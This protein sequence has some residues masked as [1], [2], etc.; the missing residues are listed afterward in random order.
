MAH[1]V[2]EQIKIIPETEFAVE[3]TYDPSKVIVVDATEWGLSPDHGIIT[4][5]TLTT[6]G[7]TTALPGGYSLTGSMTVPARMSQID[8]LNGIGFGMS[9]NKTI[10]Y[11]IGTNAAT[12]HGSVA[13]PS[14]R[15][16]PTFTVYHLYPEPEL[17]DVAMGT[18]F[19]NM[20][21][22]FATDRVLTYSYDI[23][24][25]KNKQIKPPSGGWTDPYAQNEPM[26]IQ[27]YVRALDATLYAD[28]RVV[29]YDPDNNEFVDDDTQYTPVDQNGDNYYEKVQDTTTNDY[30]TIIDAIPIR[31]VG[32]TS[33][34]LFDNVMYLIGRK[35]H[36]VSTVRLDLR[37]ET[38]A[39]DAYRLGSRF[40]N[41]YPVRKVVRQDYTGSMTIDF[42]STSTDD[43]DSI[44]LYNIFINGAMT[45]Q[46]IEPTEAG[47]GKLSV[48]V[49]VG[50][51]Y[52]IKSITNKADVRVPSAF[53]MST[54]DP[55]MYNSNIDT[56][57]LGSPN[58]CLYIL[59]N[60]VLER[61][62]KR[63]VTGQLKT[64]DLTIRMLPDDNLFKGYEV[65]DD[66]TSTSISLA[67][68]RAFAVSW[69]KG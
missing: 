4:Q 61:A 15:L 52:D 12:M 58:R 21:I 55:L 32:S 38:A 23:T 43:I 65:V 67:D 13:I 50:S 25:V 10:E 30:Y 8:K 68:L 11:N 5:E 16:L 35:I 59:P 53:G 14:Q 41:E 39:T 40:A 2:K 69:L 7:V 31:E 26:P 34:E 33:T 28:L 42:A 3:P 47:I 49:K 27:D 22:E 46:I 9:V 37:V 57:Y 63:D 24:A 36:G 60:V 45:E 64:I 48:V 19:T 44:E 66:A 51:A 6:A 54:D 1:I 29:K 18:V 62:D 20:S 56:K 17:V